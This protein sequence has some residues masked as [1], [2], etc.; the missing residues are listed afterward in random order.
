MATVNFKAL[1]GIQ[2][3][4]SFDKPQTISFDDLDPGF[5]FITGDNKVEPQLGANGAGKSSIWDALCWVLFEK[6]P[7]LLKAGNISCWHSETKTMVPL[8]MEVDGTDY[9]LTR[10]WNPNKLC[11]SEDGEPAKV[12]TN[13]DVVALIGFDFDSFLYSVLISQFSSKFFDLKPSEK[14]EVFSSVMESTLSC[15]LEFSDEAKIKRER[16]GVSIVESKTQ[17]SNLTGQITSLQEEDYSEQIEVWETEKKGNLAEIEKDIKE[18]KGEIKEVAAKTHAYDKKIEKLDDKAASISAKIT[19]LKVSTSQVWAEEKEAQG[20]R[21]DIEAD[22][23]SFEAS[24]KELSGMKGQCPTCLQEIDGKVLKKELKLIGDSLKDLE[25]D[26]EGVLD[27]LEDIV[28]RVEVLDDKKDGLQEKLT[29]ATRLVTKEETKKENNA[30]EMKTLKKEAGNLQDDYDDWMEKENPFEKMEQEKAAK[31]KRI[32]GTKWEK[33][34]ALITTEGNFQVYNYWVTG[35]KDIRYMIL[36]EALHELEIQINSSLDRLGLTGWEVILSVDKVSKK[37]NV[38][39]GFTVFVKSPVNEEPV[40]FEAWSGGEGQRLRLAGTLG[41]MD[42]I[43]DRR[44]FKTN[45]EAFDEPTTF[46]STDGVE[47]L[48]SILKDRADS[49]G[50]KIFIIDHKNLDTFS[51]FDG[52]IKVVKDEE[53]SHIEIEN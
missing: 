26:K 39:K 12:I 3:F 43:A 4:K 27:V 23:R 49:T 21:S 36:A 51:E 10:T 7:D 53:G 5:Y 24:Q 31:I 45:I 2:G 15:W 33:E 8:R 29:E 11:L 30:R 50:K 32:T 37:G 48:V 47:G 14:M 35:F 34:R 42:F 52:I 16:L 9:L 38:T 19:K 13:D 25:K 40:P 41:M 20:L 6:T 46:M 44:G 22:L 17:L 18:N 28:N 1:E